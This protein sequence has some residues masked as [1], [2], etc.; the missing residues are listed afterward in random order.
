MIL[1]Y[2]KNWVGFHADFYLR[3]IY[4]AIKSDEPR[5]KSV[6][7]IEPPKAFFFENRKFWKHK[8]ELMKKFDYRL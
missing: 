4:I 1:L 5:K 6:W 7:S 3:Y 8:V 2:I